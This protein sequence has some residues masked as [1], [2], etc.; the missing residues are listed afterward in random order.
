MEI[1]FLYMIQ[2]H[3]KKDCEE[4]FCKCY[5]QNTQNTH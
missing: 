2:Q 3:T 5:I 4:A 1:F